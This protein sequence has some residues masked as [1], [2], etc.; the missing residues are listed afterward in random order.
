MRRVHWL[1]ACD[2][3]VNSSC[4]GQ[5]TQRDN[6]VNL[7]NGIRD[8]D[9]CDAVAKRKGAAFKIARYHAFSLIAVHRIFLS[10]MVR[11][12]AV[13]PDGAAQMQVGKGGCIAQKVFVTV[14]AVFGFEPN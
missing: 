3:T 12:H 13:A 11:L 1:R 7:R 5:W 2:Y 14:A 4:G 6:S 10:F 9:G 8:V